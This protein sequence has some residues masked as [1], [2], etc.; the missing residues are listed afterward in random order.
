[1]KTSTLLILLGLCLTPTLAAVSDPV[2]SDVTPRAFALVWVADEAVL[3][4]DAKIFADADGTTE[5]TT[6]PPHRLVSAEFPPAL[7]LGIVKLQVAGL[8]SGS[9][10]HVQTRTTTGS[11]DQLSP[12]A[13]PFP[14]VCTTTQ[15]TRRRADG[16]PI[17]NDL[18]RIEA[19][20]VDGVTPAVGALVL[21]DSPDLS[22]HPV[23]A[24]VVSGG[25]AGEA[26]VNLNNLFDPA[27]GSNA[28]LPD[29]AV[30]RVTELRGLHCPALDDHSLLTYAI[31]PAHEEIATSGVPLSQL[32]T[33]GDCPA[34]DTVCD[35]VIDV[36]DAQRVLNAQGA[37]T[38]EC[39]FNPDLDLTFDGTIDDQD[40]Q[41]LLDGIVAP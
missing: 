28:A 24:F 11:G 33:P 23:S 40:A 14:Q 8:A 20:V 37:V 35:G 16:S 10:Y 15:L 27:T 34:G 29:N 17:T 3:D 38:G 22:G 13:P 2:P 5:L 30:L 4:A 32:E 31:A 12:Q 26:L 21:V 36:L 6:L 18:L 39:G 9:C 1:M 19:T 7:D 25:P 41:L